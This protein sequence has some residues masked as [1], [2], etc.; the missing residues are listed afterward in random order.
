MKSQMTKSSALIA[1]PGLNSVD[2]AIEAN[3]ARIQARMKAEPAAQT[4]RPPELPVELGAMGKSL[5]ESLLS[6][7]SR[8]VGALVATDLGA[9]E[10]RLL[11]HQVQKQLGG[12]NLP[13]VN[14]A[15]SLAFSL[16]G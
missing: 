8:A 4:A 6:T 11:A 5:V 1:I 16:F 15:G 13:L 12:R 9:R 2:R 14:G 10:T 3:G 7:V